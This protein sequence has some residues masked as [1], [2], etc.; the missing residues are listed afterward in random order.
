MVIKILCIPLLPSRAR[1]EKLAMEQRS[2]ECYTAIPL[3]NGIIQPS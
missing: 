1:I 2:G 3:Y